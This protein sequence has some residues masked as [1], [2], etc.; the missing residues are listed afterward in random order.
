[1][2]G[3]KYMKQKRVSV[4]IIGATMLLALMSGCANTTTST[5]DTANMLVAAGFKTITPKTTAQQQ[6]LH[7][8]QTGQIAT[9]QKNGGTYTLSQTRLG[10]WSMWVDL[11]SIRLI[12]NSALKSTLHKRTSKLLRC[13]RTH[14]CSGVHGVAG[15]LAG[16]E[17]VM[18]Q[19]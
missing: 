2:K 12:N 11:L 18:W 6:K 8:L 5:Q 7:Q 1:M 13:I 3:T 17:W 19:G 9:I 4:M 15:E 10:T 16:D 14:Q